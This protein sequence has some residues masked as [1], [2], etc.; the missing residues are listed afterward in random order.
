[1]TDRLTRMLTVLLVLGSTICGVTTSVA[2]QPQR[3][4]TLSPPAEPRVRV[5]TWNIGSNSIF[6]DP[7]PGRG[8]DLDGGRPAQFARI[9]RAVRPD[10]IC[11]QEIQ[12]PRSADDVG[13]LLDSIIPLAGNNRRWQTYGVRKVVIATPYPLGMPG[14]GA[15]PSRT[16]IVIMGDLN[17]YLTDPAHHVETL[18]TGAIADTARYG[19][20][21]EPDWDATSLADAHPLQ[22]A[23]G[24]SSYTFGDGGGEYPPAALDRVLFTDSRLHMLGGFVLN[25]TTLD[26]LVLG[27]LG[28]H[29]VDVL[30]NATLRRFDHLPV[31]VDFRGISGR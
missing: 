10:V 24:P 12:P 13:A 6:A 9:V 18:M 28:L 5:M 14:D 21:M 11:L 3:L 7:G 15:L 26:S 16:P 22:N 1:M 20:G 17:A 8:A 30:R 19:R 25:T 2:Q 23:V 29:A 4:A 31:V 27:R